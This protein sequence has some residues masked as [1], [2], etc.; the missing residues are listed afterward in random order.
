MSILQLKNLLKQNYLFVIL[1][2][3]AFVVHFAFLSYP[4]QTVFDEV[5]YG[6]YVTSYLNHRYFFDN[7]PPLGKLIIT[8]WAKLTNLKEDFDFSNI[9]NAGSSKL[10]FDL[11]FMPALFGSLFVL[12]FS[13]LAYLISRSKKT[14]LIAGFLVLFDNAFLVQSRLILTDIFLLFFGALTFCFFFLYQRQKSFSAKWFALLLF[15]GVSIGLTAS[16]KWTGLAMLGIITV[17]LL[18]KIFVPKF[19]AWL[20]PSA[21]AIET[22]N[23]FKYTKEAMVSFTILIFAAFTVYATTFSVHFKLIE[24]PGAADTFGSAG[25]NEQ[26]AGK[27]A[28]FWQKF[29]E[30]N[31]TMFN[32]HNN[33]KD[34]HPFSSRWQTWPFDNKPVYYWVRNSTKEN[35]GV[36][37][38]IYFLGNPIV[39]FLASILIAITALRMFVKKERRKMKSVYY[40]LLLGFFANLLPFIF[41]KRISFLYHYLPAVSFGIILLSL[42]LR[43]LWPKRKIVLFAVL[44]AVALGFIILTPLSYGWPMPPELDKFEMRIID[45]LS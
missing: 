25:F 11:R 10:F 7:H 37:S 39:W 12:L 8:G 2:L 9:G 30:L 13:Y 22:K 17:L 23:Y 31:T 38:K 16:I 40:F 19:A 36:M 33:L 32:S 29:I 1:A 21:T 26:V 43:E 28:T 3:L 42:Y 34:T 4:S 15:A 18:A 20:T 41:I 35:P 45:F 24:Q 14:A 5:H 6:R 27:P 44:V